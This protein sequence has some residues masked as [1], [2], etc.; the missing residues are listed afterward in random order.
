M[1]L[2]ELIYVHL[3]NLGNKQKDENLNHENPTCE[4]KFSHYELSILSS[5]LP[6]SSLCA[7]SPLTLDMTGLQEIIPS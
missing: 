2:S 7:K 5:T 6:G 1:N 4:D 3:S